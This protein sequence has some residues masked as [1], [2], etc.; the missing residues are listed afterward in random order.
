MQNP[1]EKAV[2]SLGPSDINNGSI[3]EPGVEEADDAI[4]RIVIQSVK[5]FINDDPVR[6]VQHDT[7][8][9]QVLLFIIG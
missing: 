2:L 1:F 9:N 5:D 8:E 6:F 7:C 4:A 3:L